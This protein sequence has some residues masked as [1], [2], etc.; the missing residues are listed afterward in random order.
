[1]AV[2]VFAERMRTIYTSHLVLLRRQLLR[3]RWRFGRHVFVHPF[4][5]RTSTETAAY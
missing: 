1:M 3:H 5:V 2:P 4:L